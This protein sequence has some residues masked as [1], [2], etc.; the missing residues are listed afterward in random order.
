MC[1]GGLTRT[2]IRWLV[3]G[4]VALAA[5]WPGW[6]K[7]VR[8]ETAAP[9]LTLDAA[10]TEP[11][12]EPAKAEPFGFTGDWGGQRKRLVEEGVAFGGW[13]DLDITRNWRGGVDTE[14]TPVRYLLDLHVALDGEKLWHLPGASFLVDFQSHDG[15]DAIKNLTGDLQGFDNNDA[16]TFVQIYQLW[17]EQ[18]WAGEALRTKIGK[19]DTAAEF[20]VM[21]HSLDFLNA[22]MPW[23]I[24]I[25]AF[26]SYP[27][28]A[29]GG[30]VYWKPTEWFYAN[31]GLF[32]SNA[33][34]RFLEIVGHPET[35][36]TSAGGIF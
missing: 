23:S 11:A 3:C 30:V 27:D 16:R 35:V 21:P 2:S 25:Y 12:T 24:S 28:P 17:W 36:R 6:V 32:H 19:M 5:A 33:S 31:G 14:A 20:S 22:T 18:K 26:P 13:C 29:P 9:M 8:A 15:P 4:V 7:D 34:E 1:M 10:E